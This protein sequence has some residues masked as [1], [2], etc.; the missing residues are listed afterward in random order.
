MQKSAKK[1]R[2]IVKKN[3]QTD[4]E[5]DDVDMDHDDYGAE[6][7]IN[8]SDTRLDVHVKHQFLKNKNIELLIKTKYGEM[9][10]M[11]DCGFNILLYGIGTKFEF[12][13]LFCQKHLQN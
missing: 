2:T 7:N 9:K 5:D 8:S 11:L 13:N 3:Y 6:A 1:Q 10:Y 12:L 4:I